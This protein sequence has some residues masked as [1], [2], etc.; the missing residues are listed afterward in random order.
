M[1]TVGVD[2][3]ESMLKEAKKLLPTIHFQKINSAAIPYPDNQF[4]LVFSSF[5]LFEI[6]TLSEMTRVLNEIYRVLKTDGIFI[7]ITGTTDMYKHEWLSLDV[8]FEENKN[9]KSGDI[10]TVRLKDEN[11]IVHDHY[12]TAT[13]YETVIDNTSFTTVEVLRPLGETS[14]GYPWISEAQYPPYVIYLLKK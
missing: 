10:A 9:L 13:D 3:D 12:W 14:D 1:E 11:V 2:I 6:A 8:D 7:G 4:D 5:V